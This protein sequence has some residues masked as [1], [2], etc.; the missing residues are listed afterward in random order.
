MELIGNLNE[1]LAGA[2]DAAPAVAP[3][4]AG[5][6]ASV[7]GRAASSDSEGKVVETAHSEGSFKQDDTLGNRIRRKSQQLGEA[8]TNLFIPSKPGEEASA[9]AEHDISS[10][11][12]SSNLGVVGRAVRRGSQAL[13]EFVSRI[14]E[15]PH[16]PP[17]GAEVARRLSQSSA[18]L[19]QLKQ[20]QRRAGAAP[21]S[22]V[23]S[24]EYRAEA[25]A[26]A[27]ERCVL[28]RALCPSEI[29]FVCQATKVVKIKAGET[30]YKQGD[31]P[32]FLYLVHSGRFDAVVTTK[33][34]G[35]WKAR[36]YGP[37]DSFGGCELLSHDMIAH[38]RVCTITAITNGVLWGI[39]QRLVELKLRVPPPPRAG[40]DL[41]ALSKFTRHLKMLS[42]LTDEQL[43]QFNRCAVQI[44]LDENEAVCKEGDLARDVYAMCK[45]IVYTSQE[46]SSFSM[47]MSPPMTFGESAFAYDES[48]RIRQ[49]K[50]FAGEDGATLVRWPVNE[51]ETLVGYDLH[52]ACE[53]LFT[54]KF[55]E[56]IICGPRPLVKG[57]S[58]DQ[59]GRLV[60]LM[61]T[62][63]YLSGE[64]VVADGKMDEELFFI[65]SGEAGASLDAHAKVAHVVDKLTTLSKCDCFGEQALVLLNEKAASAAK[66]AKRRIQL[67]AQ[68]DAPLTAFVLDPKDVQKEPDL[69]VW[70][71]E[72]IVDVAGDFV[73]GVDAV[74][75]KR[76]TDEG[77]NINEMLTKPKKGKKG[78]GE[79]GRGGRIN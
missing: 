59:V 2:P 66:P 10:A 53:R 52:A 38:G 11:A 19:Q 46:G 9:S 36:E 47:S 5:G 27:V 77:T 75:F 70:L 44:E 74:V 1:A 13:V 48:M 41:A 76:A 57:L 16:A 28:L 20:R 42:G 49:A 51:I 73:A 79:K 25:W 21:L 78:G 65:K 6:G 30:L 31:L 58:S 3:D 67:M 14:T 12:A 26:A 40:M 64:V 32:N 72:L 8:M 7:A 71:S 43:V 39:P 45:G 4:A 17:T 56:P 24:K 37:C 35:S 29:E 33:G 69:N 50:V 22:K 62:R 34:G 63:T 18:D 60:E 15:D 55:F 23:G 68:G 54:C 61:T